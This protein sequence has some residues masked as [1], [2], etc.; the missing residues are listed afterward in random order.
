[1]LSTACSSSLN[2]SSV[3]CYVQRAVQTEQFM[4]FQIR[5]EGPLTPKYFLLSF[6]GTPDLSLSINAARSRGSRG[7]RQCCHKIITAPTCTQVSRCVIVPIYY[8]SHLMACILAVALG[9]H[10][11]IG[12]NIATVQPVLSAHRVCVL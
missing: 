8:H 3:V 10:A 2:A 5:R 1:M 11:R 6:N 7:P 12:Y 4:L 9:N